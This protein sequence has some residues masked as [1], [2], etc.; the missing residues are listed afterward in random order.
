ME[1]DDNNET[2]AATPSHPLLHASRTHMLPLVP[3]VPAQHNTNWSHVSPRWRHVAK[4]ALEQRLTK[5]LF[6]PN[7][8]QRRLQNTTHL[9]KDV[10]HWT[11]EWIFHHSVSNTAEEKTTTTISSSATTTPTSTVHVITLNE[12]T[13][14]QKAMEHS[15]LPQWQSRLERNNGST[16]VTTATAENDVK[17]LIK[18]IPL[19][20]YAVISPSAMLRDVLK[21]RAVIEFP[22]IEVVPMER[23]KEFPI[24]LQEVVVP[25]PEDAEMEKYC[26]EPAV[27]QVL[28]VE[29]NECN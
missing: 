28:K 29:S 23:L 20:T 12:S 21:E 4:F 2:V 10:L 16:A 7:G 13:Q 1:Q 24:A 25:E 9:K 19:K 11:V 27:A 18:Q 5:M 17:L 6:M 26:D 22:T 15:Q 8:M 3:A 14:L